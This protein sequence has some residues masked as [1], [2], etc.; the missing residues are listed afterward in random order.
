MVEKNSESGDKLIGM[1]AICSHTKR[2]EATIIQTIRDE[3]F[4]AVKNKQQVYEAS[5]KQID[6]WQKKQNNK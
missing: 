3:G 5:K 6:V 2:S 4:P 1:L